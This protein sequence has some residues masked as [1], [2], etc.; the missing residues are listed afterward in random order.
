MLIAVVDSDVPRVDVQLIPRPQEPS[1]GVGEVADGPVIAAIANVLADAISV[2]I[3][4][5]P[6]IV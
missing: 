1:L 3:R 6:L 5:L 2:R 4:R